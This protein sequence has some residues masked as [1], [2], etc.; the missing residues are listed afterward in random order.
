[1]YNCNT[2]FGIDG[3]LYAA[4]EC[5]HSLSSFALFRYIA[6]NKL[7]LSF[8]YFTMYLAIAKSTAWSSGLLGVY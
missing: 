4:I 3:K 1:M 6:I 7:C 5:G 8:R 2:N